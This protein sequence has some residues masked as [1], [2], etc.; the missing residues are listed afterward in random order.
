MSGSSGMLRWAT[1]NSR[2]A[3]CGSG[4]TTIPYGPRRFQAMNRSFMTGIWASAQ[5][6]AAKASVRSARMDSPLPACARHDA[7]DVHARGLNGPVEQHRGD[8]Y[9]L[10][11]LAHFLG[12]VSRC[13]LI[14]GVFNTSVPG[15]NIDGVA[16]LPV[17]PGII[18]FRLTL[19]QRQR[20]N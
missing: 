6:T 4:S 18:R 14:V 11:I 7:A 12:G 1:S 9:F 20:E 17:H 13:D 3:S 15:W 16:A 19:G 8:Q 2:F 10:A 5:W